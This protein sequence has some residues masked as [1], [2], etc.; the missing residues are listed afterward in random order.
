MTMVV[1]HGPSGHSP[2][3]IE[4]VTRGVADDPGVDDVS[5]ADEAHAAATTATSATRSRRLGM[6]ARRWASAPGS[7]TYHRPMPVLRTRLDPA[8]AETRA[9]Q[10]AMTSLVD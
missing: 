9:N 2:P 6:S 5:G 7:A 4:L 1:P 3:R 10:D 8:A